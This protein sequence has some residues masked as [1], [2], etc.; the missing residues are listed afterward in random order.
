M[1]KVTPSIGSE[2]LSLARLQHSGVVP[3][4]SVEEFP[5][6]GLRA[7][8]MPYLGG[9]TLATAM[10]SLQSR[11]S[12]QRTGRDLAELIASDMTTLPE[13]TPFRGPA[14]Q[15]LARASYSQAV[16]WIGACLADALHYAHER[17]LLHL[18]VKPSNVLLASDGQPMLLDFHLAQETADIDASRAD[19]IGGTLGYMAPEQQQLFEAMRE[20]KSINTMLNRRTDIYSLGVLLHELLTGTLPAIDSARVSSLR[21]TESQ[22]GEK[23]PGIPLTQWPSDLT[24]IVSRCLEP[25]PSS[26]YASAESLAKDLRKCLAEPQRSGTTSQV[27]DR[28]QGK[29]VIG[30][31]AWVAAWVLS[32][33]LVL[34]FSEPLK[35]W[36]LPAFDSSTAIAKQAEATRQL[37]RVVEQLTTLDMSLQDG[38]RQISDEE[39]Q[40]VDELCQQV[41]KQRDE[42]LASATD[43]FSDFAIFHSFSARACRQ[44]LRCI[45]CG[46]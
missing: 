19:W 42:L 14:N 2:H 28:I 3:V 27:A 20:G 38:P 4:Y 34:F 13:I 12:S 45:S 1:L 11:K 39:L 31:V 30:W 21:N 25:D 41:W 35:A 10:E 6:Q 37:H 15:F 24:T 26:R 32:L 43:L 22:K 33:G 18:D 5:D 40:A 29:K 16:C 17:G 8:C 7:L 46:P 36:L 44:Q 23:K 9:L